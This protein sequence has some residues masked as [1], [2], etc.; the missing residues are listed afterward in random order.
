MPDAVE[1]R[2][3]DGVIVAEDDPL[4]VISPEATLVTEDV[5]DPVM[6][7]LEIAEGV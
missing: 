2:T 6:L 5:E 1:E 3:P 4:D 7:T